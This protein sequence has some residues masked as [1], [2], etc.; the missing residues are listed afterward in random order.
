MWWTAEK[1]KEKH[2]EEDS[3]S[4]SE[5]SGSCME[6]G[7]ESFYSFGWWSP[8]WSSSLWIFPLLYLTGCEDED[9]ESK[10]GLK[11]L[12]IFHSVKW[13]M[14]I[15]SLS[16]MFGHHKRQMHLSATAVNAAFSPLILLITLDVFFP[17]HLSKSHRRWGWFNISFY[18]DYSDLLHV[19]TVYFKWKKEKIFRRGE[20]EGA[21]GV[22]ESSDLQSLM[23]CPI[24][25][26]SSE[27]QVVEI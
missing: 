21:M 10:G 1:K 4:Q 12:K 25:F 22:L 19:N 16:F 17:S 3:E 7:V 26:R 9:D 13:F 5:S 20:E 23:M 8:W 18:F 14:L 2:H 24:L 6:L 15:W 27:F 11:K